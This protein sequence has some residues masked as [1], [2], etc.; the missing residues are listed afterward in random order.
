MTSVTQ[1]IS[2]T[3]LATVVVYATA[4][5]TGPL[6]ARL[7]G[8]E[9]RGT[10]VAIQLWPSALA[11]IAMLGLPDAIVLACLRDDKA[12]SAASYSAHTLEHISEPNLFFSNCYDRLRVGG[13]LAIEVPHFNLAMLGTRVLSIIGAVHPLGLSQPFFP[14]RTAARGLS[15]AWA[16]TVIGRQSPPIAC[17]PLAKAT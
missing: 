8:P 17:P 7:L 9:G 10:L 15:R 12:S 14:S 13:L 16:F 6:A 1:W 2:G 3:L 4:A 5:L 11:T